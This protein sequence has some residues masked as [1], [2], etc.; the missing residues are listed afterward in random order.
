MSTTLSTPARDAGST[1]EPVLPVSL[2]QLRAG[3]RGRLHA[4]RLEVDDR[5][6]LRALGLAEHSRFQVCKAG[7]PWIL[8][9]RSTRVG[10]SDA[11]AERILVIPEP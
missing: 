4:T 2:T 5:E 9:V 11:V 8:L 6:M 3:D 10:M 1:P 7:D